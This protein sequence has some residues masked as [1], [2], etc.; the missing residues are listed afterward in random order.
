ME[1]VYFWLLFVVG[2][3]I[4]IAPIIIAIIQLS[5]DAEE[6]AASY[7][8]SLSVLLS[9]LIPV[10][11]INIIPESTIFK[12]WYISIGVLIIVQTI[13]S[14]YNIRKSIHYIVS[15]IASFAFSC[16]MFFCNTKLTIA[17][18]NFL[19]H[20]EFETPMILLTFWLPLAV[21]LII[22]A[23]VLRRKEVN[24]V[25]VPYKEKGDRE[26]F[27]S[28]S[29]MESVLMRRTMENLT[30]Q[31]IQQHQD[32]LIRLQ[33]ISKNFSK[34]NIHKIVGTKSQNITLDRVVIDTVEKIEKDLATLSNRVSITNVKQLTVTNQ[35]LVRELTHFI[36]TPLATIE[37]T[38]DLIP[39]SLNPNSEEKLNQYISRIKSAVNICK[40]IL[41]TYREIFL[42][43]ISSEDSSLKN[44]IN[45]S[46]EV[47]KGGK[48]VS[49]K[50]DVQDKYD[51]ISNYYI[52]STIL[53]VLANAVRASKEN[54]EI[55]V[56]ELQGTIKISNTYLDN[57][58]IS[59][60]ETDGFSTK[61]NHK[62]MGLYTVR[63]LLASRK[64]GT[65]KISKQDDKIV[66][67]IPIC[68]QDH[69]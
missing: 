11:G 44:L 64:A 31:V 32:L 51:G 49:I 24:Y 60:L 28:T 65:L 30:Q 34:L 69:E 68:I 35:I 39:N 6:G 26:Y 5:E 14:I 47:Y 46:F 19:P 25:Q 20:L 9:G 50:I 18:T 10:I 61:E 63:H 16:G 58:E 33:E 7:L 37:T 27:T 36:A 59:D 21:I 41:Q 57:V 43:S 8:F 17:N 40:G 62:G 55:E 54:S 3:V 22:A 23:L 48:N 45:D 2:C 42:C 38:C 66:F 67:E 12:S 53:P 1:N 56:I 29:S 15:L 13:V 4:V 52:L